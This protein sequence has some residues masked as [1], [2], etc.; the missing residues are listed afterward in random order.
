[1][2]CKKYDV[3]RAEIH[4]EPDALYYGSPVVSILGDLSNRPKL[5]RMSLVKGSPEIHTM[6]EP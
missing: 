3:R 2:F 5:K 6:D 4:W 1:M